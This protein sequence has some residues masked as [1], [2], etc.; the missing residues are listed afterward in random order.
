M[1]HRWLAAVLALTTLSCGQPFENLPFKP[2]PA[3]WAATCGDLSVDWQNA[4]CQDLQWQIPACAAPVLRD[5]ADFGHNIVPLPVALTYTESPPLS[6]PHRMDWARWGEYAFLPPSRWLYNAE[7]GGVAMLYN[8]CVPATFV[9]ELRNFLRD[10]P[11]DETGNF[12]WVL[13]PYPNLSTAF[14]MVTWQHSFSANCLDSDAASVFLHARYRHAPQDVATTGPYL[15]AWIGKLT[16]LLTQPAAPV[17][18]CTDA[19]STDAL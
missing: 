19:G 13:T 2:D 7:L 12:R 6:G 4:T 10:Q 15:Y 9:E 14:A 5:A 17:P 11:D 18:V 8:P 1:M 3:L 16:G